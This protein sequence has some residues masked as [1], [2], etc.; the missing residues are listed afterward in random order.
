[1]FWEVQVANELHWLEQDMLMQVVHDAP[2]VEGVQVVELLPPLPLP[3]LLLEQAVA[4]ASHAKRMPPPILVQLVMK[5]IL[6]A[7]RCKL[8][9]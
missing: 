2:P 7:K 5:F 3:L 9:R 6:Q 4:V 8:Q 1:M